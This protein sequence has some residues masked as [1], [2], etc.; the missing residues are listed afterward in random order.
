ML[1]LMILAKGIQEAK[2]LL[3]IRS[4]ILVGALGVAPVAI[5]IFSGFA[6]HWRVLGRHL[7]ATLP[8][9]NL[10]IA[11]GLAKLYERETV[12][13]WSWRSAIAVCFLLAFVYS[14]LSLRF[15]DRHRKDDYRAAATLAKEELASGKRIWWAADALGARYYG[16]PGEFDY[17]GELTN[18]HKPYACIDQSGVQPV[19][20]A[21]GECL[22]KLL[23]PDTVILSKP[24]AFDKNGAIAAYLRAGNFAHARELPAFTIW[25]AATSTDTPTT[26]A[27]PS[28]K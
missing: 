22:A 13:L 26:R 1:I 17:I 23:R 21:S 11:I 6:M 3:G 14:S 12:R 2:R 24:E 7:I 20:A 28:E 9:L 8:L 5:V 27:R 18:I 25:R 10:L 15:A 19:S 4:L 16:L